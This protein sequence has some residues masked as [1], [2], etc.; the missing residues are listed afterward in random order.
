MSNE[1]R[2]DEMV[3]ET[4]DAEDV[5]AT[6]EEEYSYTS[7]EPAKSGGGSAGIWVIIVLVVA[8]LIGVGWYQWQQEQDKLAEQQ[9]DR[10]QIYQRQLSLISEDVTDAESALESGD[11]DKMISSLEEAVEQLD[12]MARSANSA[13]DSEQANQM[14]AKKKK[15]QDAIA[16][17]QPV[18]EK[19]E[20][21]REELKALE[22]ELMTTARSSLDSV[23]GDFSAAG[24][25]PADPAVPAG[26]A[27][28]PAMAEPEADDAEPADAGAAAEGDEAA[29]TDEPAEGDD[30]ADAEEAAEGDEAAAD[31]DAGADD[32][33]A[34]DDAPEDD[35]AMEPADEDP[36]G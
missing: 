19:I 3:D 36:A 33:P 1:E 31:D 11:L 22:D 35:V 5:E 34:E 15:I 13:G 16:S 14:L 18:Y 8:A 29:A 28:D 32:A 2:N 27:D 30:A 26:P 25:V 24:G 21:K 23:A 6:E 7:E 9:A 17:L 20:A 4:S 12:I 10:Q